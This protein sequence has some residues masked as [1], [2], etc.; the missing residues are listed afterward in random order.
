MREAFWHGLL[1]WVRERLVEDEVIS[2]DD[3]DLLLLTDDPASV[4]E[5]IRAS[6]DRL[7][8]EDQANG[9]GVTSA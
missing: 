8:E 6:Q 5:W 1:R 4:V 3:P 2:A 9:G 7:A